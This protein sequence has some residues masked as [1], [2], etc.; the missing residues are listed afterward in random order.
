MS[1]LGQLLVGESIAATR[2]NRDTGVLA[3]QKAVEQ[4]FFKVSGHAGWR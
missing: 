2:V 1:F 4:S 3:D